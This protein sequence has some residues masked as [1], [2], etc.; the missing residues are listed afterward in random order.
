MKPAWTE[1]QQQAIDRVKT[2]VAAYRTQ[3]ETMTEASAD[4]TDALGE[5][6]NTGISV[7]RLVKI[8][9]LATQTI[10][11]RLNKYTPKQTPTA[12]E[13]RKETR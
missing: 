3:D 11:R 1:E 5:A 4:L 8:T 12:S 7:Y 10:N 2:S 6:Y 9:D 13:Q